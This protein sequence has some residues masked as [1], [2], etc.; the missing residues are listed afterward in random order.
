VTKANRAFELIVRRGGREPAFLADRGRLDRV[1]IVYIDDGE[2][3]LFWELPAKEA[4]KLVK[5]LR[6]DLVR[7]DP[8]DF[9]ETWEGR[10]L[11]SRP[12]S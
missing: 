6:A 3:V 1:E 7:L 2:V 10:D 11:R 4:A 8:G 5:E 12:I 9:I